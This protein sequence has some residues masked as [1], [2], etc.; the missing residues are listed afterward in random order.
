MADHTRCVLR[1]HALTAFP[2]QLPWPA[3]ELAGVVQS[4]APGELHG[5]GEVTGTLHVGEAG[6]EE[7]VY[8]AEA[9]HHE[10]ILARGLRAHP[11]RHIEALTQNV[12]AAVT[13][14]QL[15]A[16]GRLFGQAIR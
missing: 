5:I 3:V 16:D 2:Y 4:V 13:S 11:Q 10:A 14:V 6:H 7:L 9:A 12:H 15:Q 1:A 8:I